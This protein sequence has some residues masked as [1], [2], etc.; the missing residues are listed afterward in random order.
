MPSTA[1]CVIGIIVGYLLTAFAHKPK[2][3]LCLL[4]DEGH[5]MIS[6]DLDH[7]YYEGNMNLLNKWSDEII[8][9]KYIV[10]YHYHPNE[11]ITIS[12]PTH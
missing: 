8:G 7:L 6:A 12:S 3:S 1:I 5:S 11:I 2:A 9:H 4:K 10:W